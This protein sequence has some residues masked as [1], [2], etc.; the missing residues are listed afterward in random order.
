MSEEI[1]FHVGVLLFE[2]HIH[3]AQSLKEKRSVVKRIKEQLQ[4]RFS[5]SVAEVGFQDKWQR[6]ACAVSLVSNDPREIQTIFDS[7]K[8]WLEFESGVQLIHDEIEIA[9]W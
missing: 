2:F 6:C 8:Q 9:A 3:A 4:N 1:S 5:A 7:M